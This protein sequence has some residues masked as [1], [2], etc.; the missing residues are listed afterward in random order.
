MRVNR[1][2]FFATLFAAPLVRLGLK[3]A[4][5]PVVRMPDPLVLPAGHLEMVQYRLIVMQADAEAA[6][7]L[8][9]TGIHKVGDRF[10]VRMPARFRP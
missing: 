4:P 6:Y 1:R 7:W 9:P 2:G 5:I 3:A 8:D 10:K